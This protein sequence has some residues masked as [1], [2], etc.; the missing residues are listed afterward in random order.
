MVERIEPKIDLKVESELDEIIDLNPTL[1]GISGDDIVVIRSK[2]RRRNISAY[3]QGGKII[4]SIPARL[5]KAEEREIVPEMIAR[6]RAQEVMVSESDL[7]KLSNRLLEELAPEISTRAAKVSWRTMNERWG[8]CTNI[9]RTIRISTKLSTAPDYVLEYVLFHE[10]IHLDNP[11]HDQEFN[12]VL[13]RFPRYLE[14][15]AFLAGFEAGS[16]AGTG[17]SGQSGQISSDSDQIAQ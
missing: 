3:R 1:P 6:V 4:I 5:S 16:A 7:S 17:N 9:D 2:K 11:S 13:R 10:S 15:E 14:A 8:S 12:S